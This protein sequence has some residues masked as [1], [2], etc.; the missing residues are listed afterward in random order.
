MK[1][2]ALLSGGKDSCYNAVKCVEHG[3]ELVCLANLLPPQ[4]FEG[5]ELNSF[6][7]QSAA[8]NAIPALAECFEVPLIRRH[9]HGQALVQ[10]LDYSNISTPSSTA[11]TVE[12]VDDEVEDLYELLLEV[13]QQFPDCQGISCGAIVSTYQRLRLE[14]VC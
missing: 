7:Y 1:F 2:V 8:Y 9:I 12:A 14:H 3:H 5:E 4:D 10:S 11:S 13:K 6:M